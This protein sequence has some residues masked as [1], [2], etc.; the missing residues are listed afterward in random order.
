MSKW[1]GKI[2]CLDAKGLNRVYTKD[3]VYEVV[4][5][6]IF[7]DDCTSSPIHESFDEWCRLRGGKWEEVKDVKNMCEIADLREMLKPC[8]FVKCRDEVLRMVVQCESKII[9]KRFDN[10]WW[11]D[12]CDYDN[13]LMLENRENA[14]FDIIEVYGYDGEGG[15][16]LRPTV[17]TRKL[18]W[19]REEKTPQ[20]I[21]I[22]QIEAEQRKLAD[23]LS[24]LRKGL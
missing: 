4:N 16:S 21:E 15:N 10:M 7:R 19:K 13:V 18:I 3:K 5:G 9:I 24:E 1:N 14:C 8:M 6:S 11:I 2:R 22:E 20:Q 23:R 12:V 17:R